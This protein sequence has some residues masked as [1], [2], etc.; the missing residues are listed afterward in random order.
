MNPLDYL[1]GIGHVH[2]HE[3]AL[4]AEK[5]GKTEWQ[6]IEDMVDAGW[7]QGHDALG[8]DEYWEPETTEPAP[9]HSV[10]GK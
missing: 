2:A 7:T 6:V 5:H 1:K 4:F 3:F 9:S 10:R 8:W